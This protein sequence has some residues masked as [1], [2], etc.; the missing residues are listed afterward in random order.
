MGLTVIGSEFVFHSISAGS[1]WLDGNNPGFASGMVGHINL[2]RIS[3]VITGSLGFT[4]VFL[5]FMLVEWKKSTARRVQKIR[6]SLKGI[7]SHSPD[8]ILI[9]GSDDIACLAEE[10]NEFVHK[11]R[12]LH[13]DDKRTITHSLMFDKLT[14]VGEVAA[15]AAHEI[16]NPLTSIKGFTYLLQNKLREDDQSW[17][18]AQIINNEVTRIE[19][20]IDQ[21]LL[22]AV[23]T[24]PVYRAANLH[25]LIDEILVSLAKEAAVNGVIVKTDF[26]EQLPTVFVDPLQIKRMFSNLCSNAIQAMPGGGSLLIK[27]VS[28]Y[29]RGNITVILKDT[30]TG[31]PPDCI[32]R[33]A[34]PFFTTKEN[35][36]GLGLTVSYRIVQNHNGMLQVVSSQGIGTTCVIQ[37]PFRADRVPVRTACG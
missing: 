5:A 7:Y 25:E 37:L 18:Y 4:T 35:A 8:T 6:E 12:Q 28:D 29:D 30:G 22:M 36:A 24:F 10:L 1:P 19:K 26:S 23:P 27:T 20:I 13:E 21:F 14:A 3:A 32:G 16:R 2:S 9:S 31:I 15:G 34:D 17:K 33:V 11:I